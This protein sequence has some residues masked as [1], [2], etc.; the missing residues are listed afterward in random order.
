MYNLCQ[1]TMHG[2]KAT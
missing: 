1:L 2:E